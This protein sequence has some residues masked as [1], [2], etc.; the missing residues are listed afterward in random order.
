MKTK[1]H[2]YFLAVLTY[3]LLLPN[4][5]LMQTE[6]ECVENVVLKP[7]II[8]LNPIGPTKLP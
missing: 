5:V 2:Y 3:D 6:V 4:L 8:K 7:N 1:D